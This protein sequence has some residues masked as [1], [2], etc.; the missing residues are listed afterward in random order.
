[1]TGTVIF[2]AT[3]KKGSQVPTFL[4]QTGQSSVDVPVTVGGQDRLPARLVAVRLPPTAAAQR[5]R[6][7][8]ETERKKGSTPRAERWALCDGKVCLTNVPE[9][10]LTVKAVLVLARAR[11][12]I[13]WLVKQW[14]SHGCLD[15][16]TAPRPFARLCHRYAK[17]LAML[18]QHWQILTSLCPMT[19]LI[20]ALNAVADGLRHGGVLH[21]R[22]KKPSPFPL[23]WDVRLLAVE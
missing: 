1:L 14:K 12:H 13:E 21:R 17:M 11:W 4:L 10:L 3:G 5:R 2:D 20:D 6:K 16:G 15:K 22:A 23:V 9:T 7:L 18:V 8:R 19:R